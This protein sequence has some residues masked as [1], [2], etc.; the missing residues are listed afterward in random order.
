MRFAIDCAEVPV[1]KVAA[2]RMVVD[3]SV[4][5]MPLNAITELLEMT[6]QSDEATK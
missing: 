2:T 3:L 4:L 6:R 5:V 1:A